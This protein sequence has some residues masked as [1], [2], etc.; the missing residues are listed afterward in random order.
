MKPLAWL[1]DTGRGTCARAGVKLQP[2]PHCLGGWGFVQFLI[3]YF[4]YQA[5][6]RLLAKAP[7]LPGKRM[8]IALL[9][10]SHRGG[11]LGKRSAW[12]E[13]PDPGRA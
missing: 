11:P 1:A 3:P 2:G 7:F 8:D 9:A 5:M 12:P 4:P 10:M 6:K 13:K